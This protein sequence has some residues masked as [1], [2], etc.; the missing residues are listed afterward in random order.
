MSTVLNVLGA[1]VLCGG[2]VVEHR[3]LLPAPGFALITG[4]LLAIYLWFLAKTRRR[5]APPR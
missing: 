4:A 3:G 1:L 5:I 2:V